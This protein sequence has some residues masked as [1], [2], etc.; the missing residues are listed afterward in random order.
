MCK[1]AFIEYVWES[2]VALGP[3][4]MGTESVDQASQFIKT[5]VTSIGLSAEYIPFSFD[6]WRVTRVDL[7]IQHPEKRV[8][9]ASCLLESPPTPPGGVRGSIDWVGK[10]RVWGIHDWEF[11]RLK[12]ALG[13]TV[14][15]ILGRPEYR[16]IPQAPA[17]H[18]L[19]LPHFTIGAEDTANFLRWLRQKKQIVA[20]GKI[21]AECSG[22][23][24][25]NNIR[26][27]LPRFSFVHKGKNP[28]L[29]L[30]AHYDTMFNTSGAYD[31]ASGVTVALELARHFANWGAPLS[32]EFIFTG[33]EEW[34]LRGSRHYCELLE[35]EGE[36]E[37]VCAVIVIDG[38]G[39]SKSLE[40][41]SGPEP[42]AR[43]VW[44][45]FR[46]QTKGLQKLVR[47]PPPPGSDHVPFYQKGLPVLMLTIDDQEI[48]HRPEDRIT[49]AMRANIYAV[50]ELLKEN[51]SRIATISLRM[52]V[53][54]RVGS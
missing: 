37:S 45:I 23:A 54:R 32:M 7:E 30:L 11:F 20:L 18:P 35:R 38:I 31:N 34:N 9:E 14:A 6:A 12:D 13:Q 50:C 27:R 52:Q 44:D 39:R 22:K 26:A 29:L 8:I 42:F 53:P 15:Y 28:K 43:T 36:L 24:V 21:E 4:F 48:I 40:L 19:T 17:E 16:A 51:I 1:S 49:E 25:G 5:M 47:F 33:G 2:L 41:W 3:R 10:Y 46:C